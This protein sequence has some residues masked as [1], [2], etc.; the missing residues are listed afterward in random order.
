MPARRLTVLV[1][2]L[3]GLFVLGVALAV[4][5][6]LALRDPGVLLVCLVALAAGVLAAGLAYAAARVAAEEHQEESAGLTPELPPP[7]RVALQ[8]QRMARKP[9]RPV[10]IQS[11]PVADLPAP[12]LAAVM[13]GL[14][15]SPA[16]RPPHQPVH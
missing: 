4:G 12:Y 9:Q 1:A 2:V 10:R 15:A 11:L 8:L 14:Q 13:K 7:P 16:G 5:G 3:T 6:L